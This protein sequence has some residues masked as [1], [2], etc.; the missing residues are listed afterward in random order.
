MKVAKEISNLDQSQLDQR[1]RSI[2]N[3]VIDIFSKDGLESL[4]WHHHGTTNAE[5][6]YKKPLPD[7]IDLCALFWKMI[8]YLNP[9]S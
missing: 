1:K 2:E 6:K 8:E 7:L 3:L 4:A 9:S 5:L